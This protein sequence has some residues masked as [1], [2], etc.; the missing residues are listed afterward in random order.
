MTPTGM[1]VV[2]VLVFLAGAAVGGYCFARWLFKEFI[3]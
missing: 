2:V 3:E 1:V